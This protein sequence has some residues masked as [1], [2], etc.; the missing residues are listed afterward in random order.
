MKDLSVSAV[1]VQDNLVITE[2][3]LASGAFHYSTSRVVCL[4]LSA[5]YTMSQSL[6]AS[7]QIFILGFPFSSL[8]YSGSTNGPNSSVSACGPFPSLLSPF[9]LFLSYAHMTGI[10]RYVQPGLL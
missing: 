5:V 6:P 7:F 8:K 4:N 3:P 2:H 9:R 10:S 1:P